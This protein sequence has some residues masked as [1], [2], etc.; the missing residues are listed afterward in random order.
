VTPELT[1]LADKGIRMTNYYALEYC[2]PSRA[3]LLTG[4]YPVN[5]GMQYGMVQYNIPWGLRL[6]ETLL[7]EVLKDNGYATYMFGK[8]HLGHFNERYLPTARGFDTFTGMS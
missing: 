3:S 4:R 5:M 7:P 8:W 1:K 6:D 2:N